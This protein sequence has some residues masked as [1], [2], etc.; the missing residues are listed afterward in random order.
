MRRMSPPISCGSGVK[1][2]LST[3]QKV[4]TH[5]DWLEAGGT[6]EEL[7]ALTSAQPALNANSLASWVRRWK[8]ST[9]SEFNSQ[10]P[11]RVAGDSVMYID[12][13]REKEALRICGRLEIA[14]L[15]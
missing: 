6:C 12:P 8:P 3:F 7:R 10:S 14:A 11:F 2:A 5:S 13:D 9:T 1:F 15:T 4:T